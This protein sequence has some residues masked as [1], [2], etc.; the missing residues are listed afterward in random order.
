VKGFRESY[1][2][3]EQDTLDGKSAEFDWDALYELLGESQQ[4]LSAHD[5][6]A[7]SFAFKR[8]LEWVLSVDLGRPGFESVIAR[9]ALALAWTMNPAFFEDSPS[10][11]KIAERI[12]THKVSLSS[13]AASASRTFG[14]RNR[15]Q[16]HG[17]NFKPANGGQRR[18]KANPHVDVPAFGNATSLQAMR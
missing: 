17:W 9:R 16:R 1:L 6:D 14:V 4:E 13:Y 12:G 8:V 15:G 7:L 5:Y 2:N 10:L 3:P 11:S 18:A